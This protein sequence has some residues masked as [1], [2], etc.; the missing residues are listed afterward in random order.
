MPCSKFLFP[1]L[2]LSSKTRLAPSVRRKPKWTKK[3]WD[4]VV[5]LWLFNFKDNFYIRV[6]RLGAQ[7]L[8]VGFRIKV[9]FINSRGKFGIG[10]E[11][12]D[13]SILIC[14]SKRKIARVRK[15]VCWE[16][17]VRV[18]ICL[19]GSYPFPLISTRLEPIQVYLNSS[20]RSTFSS[21]KDVW[22]EGIV[23]HR[24]DS[25]N[26]GGLIKTGPKLI[27]SRFKSDLYLN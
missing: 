21:V 15:L 12:W 3:D 18:V 22:S 9:E 19:R 24:L 1:I 6:K 20:G 10:K 26:K 4:M 13:A 23:R 8:I 2:K 5:F 17:E 27:H 11:M 25:I 7:I 16:G 14:H